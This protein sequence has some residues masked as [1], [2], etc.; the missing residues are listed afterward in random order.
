MSKV[1]DV[2]AGA[3]LITAGIVFN[4]IY[5]GIGALGVFIHISTVLM[6]FRIAGGLSALI[7]LVF[8][9]ISEVYWLI[10]IWHGTGQFFNL[11]TFIIGGYLLLWIAFYIVVFIVLIIATFIDNRVKKH[12]D[13]ER[14][15]IDV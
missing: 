1:K 15:D 10:D 3:G 4:L 5:L 2:L 7:T 14:R 9:I 12:D 8:P 13:W 11:Y 6:A